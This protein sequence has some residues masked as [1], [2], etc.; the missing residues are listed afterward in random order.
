LEAGWLTETDVV[1]DG[2]DEPR[3]L[4]P[5][6]E[7]SL[8]Q[9][10][11]VLTGGLSI[12]AADHFAYYM[13]QVPTARLFGQPTAGAFGNISVMESGD[14]SYGGI[15]TWSVQS[16]V[17]GNPLQGQSIVPDEEVRFSLES[18]DA[19]V[20]PVFEAAFTWIES[21]LP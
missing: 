7:F 11:A 17:E 4:G 21:Q 1:E 20:D 12:S 5:D 13:D 2:P 16:D 15:V 18:I 14:G 6:E 3:R 19:G 9:P 8:R 10:V